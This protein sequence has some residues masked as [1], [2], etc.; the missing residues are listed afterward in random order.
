MASSDNATPLKL[1][2]PASTISIPE[3]CGFFVPVNGSGT[4]GSGF[5]FTGKNA[6]YFFMPNEILIAAPDALN[7]NHTIDPVARFRF[8]GQNQ[9][10]RLM[11]KN[12]LNGTAH[13]F[14]GNDPSHW[15]TAVPLYGEVMYQDIYSGIDLHYREEKGHLKSTFIVAPGANPSSIHYIIEGEKPVQ[16]DPRGALVIS[17][18]EGRQITE[19]PPTAYQDVGG[20]VKSIPVG[21]YLIDEGQ[22]GYVLGRYDADYPLVIDPEIITSGYLGGTNTDTAYDIALDP[23]GTI[24]IIGETYS[25]DFPVTRTAFN[26]TW[27]GFTDIFITAYTKEGT[28]VLYSTYL[29]GAGNDNGRAIAVNPEGIVYLTGSTESPDFPVKNAFQ[30]TMAGAFDAVITA[31]SPDGSALEFSSFLGGTDIDDARDIALYG[32]NNTIHLTGVTRSKDFPLKNAVQKQSG[33]GL[34]AFIT[35]IDGKGTT[36]ISST[37]L[38]GSEGDRGQGIAV[39][40]TG[41]IY[42]T[43][44]TYSSKSSDFPVKNPLMGPH[45]YSYDAF[46]S[47]YTP[48]ALDLIYSTYLGGTWGDRAEA[49]A[50]DPNG[51]AYVIG[52]TYSD[53]YPTTPG[54]L[55]RVFGGGLYADAFITGIAPDGQSLAASTYLGGSRDDF[56]LGMTLTPD[57]KVYVTGGTTSSDFPLHEPWK[58]TLSGQTDAFVTGLDASLSNL[59]ISSYF[60]GNGSEF[61]NAIER[62]PRGVLFIAGITNSDQ[63]PAIRANQAH[64]GGDFDVFLVA[65]APARTADKIPSEQPPHLPSP[66]SPFLSFELLLTAVCGG[67]IIARVLMNKDRR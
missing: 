21:Y 56:G 37:Y 17:T 5:H 45:T 38:G 62:D 31:L 7:L 42:V 55:Q 60:G 27:S 66:K 13:F 39:D 35:V 30:P 2:D 12:L 15:Q 58:D 34:D 19:E 36:I 44:Y 29:G 48:D 49:I 25:L 6:D 18:A 47:K 20:L 46:V 28:E 52:Y 40:T 65:I 61:G 63:I 16:I 8:E 9:N 32:R 22:V 26:T 50:V 4:S 57:G 10:S 24:Y 14:I 53:D 54:A 43:G 23:Q 41:S 64:N 1:M 59:E 3:P 33:G 51:T 11:G 67:C